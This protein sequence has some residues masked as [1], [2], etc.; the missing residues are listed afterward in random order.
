MSRERVRI[1]I[2]DLADKKTFSKTTVGKKIL[3]VCEYLS[4]L[5]KKMREDI[6]NG[7]YTCLLY[8]SPSPRD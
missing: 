8:T 1:Y 3:V 7:H 5:N 4:K 6:A 2:G